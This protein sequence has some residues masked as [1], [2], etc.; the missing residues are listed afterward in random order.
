MRPKCLVLVWPKSVVRGAL[1]PNCCTRTTQYSTDIG[2]TRL[3][4]KFKVL[5]IK[6]YTKQSSARSGRPYQRALAGYLPCKVSFGRMAPAQNQVVINDHV[7]IACTRCTSRE[8]KGVCIRKI[9][10]QPLEKSPVFSRPSTPRI[11]SS[12][13]EIDPQICY[14]PPHLRQKQW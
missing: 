9:V 5:W 1:R 14:E 7:S 12:H 3:C 10:E 6:C 4:T 13:P 2:Y 11:L 8:S